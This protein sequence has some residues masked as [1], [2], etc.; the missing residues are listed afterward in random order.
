MSYPTLNTLKLTVSLAP[1]KW[2]GLED[3]F[4][5]FPFGDRQRPIFRGALA[6]SFRED[7]CYMA[8]YDLEQLKVIFSS[9]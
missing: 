9:P 1:E 8:I 3:D 2:M 4:S 7:T 5:W 6:A